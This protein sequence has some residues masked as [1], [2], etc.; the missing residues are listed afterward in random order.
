MH[1][2]KNTVSTL[3]SSPTLLSSTIRLFTIHILELQG[4]IIQTSVSAEYETTSASFTMYKVWDSQTTP[5]AF[6]ILNKNPIILKKIIN[7]QILIRQVSFFYFIISKA[8]AGLQ[9]FII[10]SFHY[11]LGASFLKWKSKPTT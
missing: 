2:A 9:Q 6:I 3:A 8:I 1:N 7:I 11:E 10:S 5:K 4:T